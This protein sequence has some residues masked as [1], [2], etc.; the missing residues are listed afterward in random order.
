[1]PREA[2]APIQ[3]GRGFVQSG[4]S[5]QSLTTGQRVASHRRAPRTCAAAAI[6]I[7]LAVLAGCSGDEAPQSPTTSLSAEEPLI[8]ISD[9]DY[10]F[11]GTFEPGATITVHNEDNVG[12]TV[13]SDT[14][15]QFDVAVGPGETVTF[16]GPDEPGDYPFHC[17]PHPSMVSTLTVG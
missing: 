16:T 1:M 5:H 10:S 4:M 9:F 7:L 3:K 12:H 11:S 14:D 13:T 6:G 15:G 8:T 2:A 17:T